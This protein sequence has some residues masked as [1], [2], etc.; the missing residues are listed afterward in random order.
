MFHQRLEHDMFINIGYGGN[1]QTDGCTTD[2]MKY[3]ERISLKQ[4]VVITN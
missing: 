4:R 2:A 1:W 3:V